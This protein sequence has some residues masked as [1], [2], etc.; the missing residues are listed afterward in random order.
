MDFLSI[1]TEWCVKISNTNWVFPLP[2]SL[3]D[4]EPAVEDDG[5]C[6]GDFCGTKLEYSTFTL[7]RILWGDWN[8]GDLE[9]EPHPPN[10]DLLEE[11]PVLG[12]CMDDWPV[13][14]G[15]LVWFVPEWPAEVPELWPFARWDWLEFW[16]K[17]ILSRCFLVSK[18]NEIKPKTRE[19]HSVSL[20]STVAKTALS[21]Y[22]VSF[23][24]N[25]VTIAGFG[26]SCHRWR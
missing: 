16:F 4:R 6:L 15:L 5:E 20:C 7:T 8:F 21:R 14:E 11:A 2:G 23:W 13:P 22:E 25:E 17:F 10:Q 1:A 18:N 19:M 26:V 9:D 24:Q 12:D 3:G